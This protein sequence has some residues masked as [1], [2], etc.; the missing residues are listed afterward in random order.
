MQKNIISIQ[1]KK[2][3]TFF[4]VIYYKHCLVVPPTL[5][6][7]VPCEH[8]IVPVR[9][10]DENILHWDFEEHNIWFYLAVFAIF[11]SAKIDNISLRPRLRHR[12]TPENDHKTRDTSLDFR[13]IIYKT[14]ISTIHIITAVA[15]HSVLQFGFGVWAEVSG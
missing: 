5:S 3:V 1:T 6:I 13:N 12:Q 14:I 15:L 2:D 9:T 10:E 7:G 11:A 8:L 4:A